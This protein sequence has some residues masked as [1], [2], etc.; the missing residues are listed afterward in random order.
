M[1]MYGNFEGFPQKN[2]H[3]FVWCHV[4]TPDPFPDFWKES[5]ILSFDV[6][7]FSYPVISA[8]ILL[9]DPYSKGTLKK[10]KML[11]P[12]VFCVWSTYTPQEIAGLIKPLFLGEYF[13]DGVLV[14]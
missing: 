3:C 8:R 2:V 6:T 7:L 4:M 13:R 12:P 14:D 9:A 1:Q 5:V 10:I 11:N